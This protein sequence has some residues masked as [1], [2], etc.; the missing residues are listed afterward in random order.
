M[1]GDTDDISEGT[2]NLYNRQADWS[3]ATNT[4]PDFIKNKPTIPTVTTKRVTLTVSDGA[5]PAINCDSGT[6][7]YA[8]WEAGTAST[9]PALSNV[10]VDS[11]ILLNIKKTISGDVTVTFSQAGYDFALVGAAAAASAAVVLS[12]VENSFHEISL[13]VTA[14]EI[15]TDKVITIRS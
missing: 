12:G 7:V 5:T 6:E 2:T 9:A 3:Q 14:H 15:S 11:V 4:A 13:A 8:K 1:T 10:V